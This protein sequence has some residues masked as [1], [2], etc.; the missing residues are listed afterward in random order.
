MLDTTTEEGIG[1]IDLKP[2]QR[3][4]E[5]KK[6]KK[7]DGWREWIG[8]SIQ[9]SKVD[10]DLEPRSKVG[11]G[12]LEPGSQL[13]MWREICPLP[14]QG[15]KHAEK[16]MQGREGVLLVGL[17]T[18]RQPGGPIPVG[19]AMQL[20]KALDTVVSIYRVLLLFQHAP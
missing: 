3:L 9:T 1:R 10:I 8:S 13:R 20:G 17:D 11:T 2:Q 16:K 6:K 4:A 19:C 18:R 14:A 12:N 15:N 5:L 7:R